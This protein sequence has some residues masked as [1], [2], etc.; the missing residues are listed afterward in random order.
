[1]KALERYNKANNLAIQAVQ[2]IEETVTQD[3][4]IKSLPL[5]YKS[6]VDNPNKVKIIERTHYFINCIRNYSLQSGV[7][8]EGELKHPIDLFR[9]TPGE[10]IK[11][12]LLSQLI[13]S[14]QQELGIW[15][16]NNSY[17]QGINWIGDENRIIGVIVKV[18]CGAYENDG[19]DNYKENYNY[20]FQSRKGILNHNTKANLSL[21]NQQKNHYPIM[22]F[23]QTSPKDKVNRKFEGY[24]F[25]KKMFEKHVVLSKLDKGTQNGYSGIPKSPENFQLTNNRQSISENKAIPLNRFTDSNKQFLNKKI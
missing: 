20:S 11:N 24:F 23:R 8:I 14:P 15:K 19:W 2:K 6:L 17:Q 13:N 3:L 9:L 5:G 10:L 21:I 18:T 12:S 7:R 22:L 25:V 16:I 4:T 1:M